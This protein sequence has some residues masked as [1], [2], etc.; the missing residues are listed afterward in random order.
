MRLIS[1]CKLSDFY[2][3]NNRTAEDD[4]HVKVSEGL[5]SGLNIT[6]LQATI[7]Q[8]ELCQHFHYNLLFSPII[9]AS[10]G[11]KH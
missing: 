6:V 10:L 1:Y 8:P 3:E 5:S 11:Y 2:R 4:K 9:I 7:G